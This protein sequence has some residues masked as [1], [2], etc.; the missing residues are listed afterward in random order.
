M[1]ES[2]PSTSPP[3]PH[4]RRWR[5]YLLN[6]RFQLK[7]SAY[8]VGIATLLSV[9]LGAILWRTSEAGITESRKAVQ[10]GEQVVARGREVLQESQKVSA[11]VQMN[12]VK[13]PVYGQN[14]ALLEAFRSD[15]AERDT[16]L[17]AQQRAL[18]DQARALK[19]QS[20]LLASRQRGMLWTLWAVLSAFVI[21]VGLAG[22][23][24]T[25]RVAG[26][27]FKMK[28]QI[29]ELGAGRLVLPSPL[30]KGDE[31]I[32]FFRAFERMVQSLRKRQEEEIEELERAI[33]ALEPSARPGDLRPLE[34][35]R[36]RMKGSL[37]G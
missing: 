7:Y 17:R 30:R 14:P 11:V 8:L 9:C 37:D 27:I 21:A 34:R 29:G 4:K 26:P 35:L 25:H 19:Q 33:A 12:I 3:P 28:R 20:T 2:N 1:G 5:N 6:S 32:D 24:V 15:S 36:D 13:D 10:Q 23:I 22:I 16:R 18:E 31:L